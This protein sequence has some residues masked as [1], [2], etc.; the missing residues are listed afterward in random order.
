MYTIQTIH[1]TFTAT[2]IAGTLP[3]YSQP[4]RPKLF[5]LAMATA[6]VTFDCHGTR[7]NPCHLWGSDIDHEAIHLQLHLFAGV[8]LAGVGSVLMIPGPRET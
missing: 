3:N 1:C 2:Q 6:E 4:G 5:S 7:R 8:L